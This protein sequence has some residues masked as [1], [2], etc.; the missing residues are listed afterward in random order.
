MPPRTEE[1]G[2]GDWDVEILHGPELLEAVEKGRM[3]CE[4]A[5]TD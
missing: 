1:H 3:E 2:F 5:S 4:S